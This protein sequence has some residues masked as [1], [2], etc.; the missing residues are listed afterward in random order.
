MI[1]RSL[2]AIFLFTMVAC[3]DTSASNETT[4]Q[5]ALQTPSTTAERSLS[6]EDVAL[7]QTRAANGSG[8]DAY[9]LSMY[10]MQKGDIS[11]FR[12]W[13]QI[14]AENGFP[15]GMHAFGLYLSINAFGDTPTHDSQIRAK[16]W[17]TRAKDAGYKSSSE[18]ISSN[19]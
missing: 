18:G 9:K 10:Y 7:L 4:E 1:Y 5:P 12:H 11:D 14:S 13:L 3:V 8:E 16:Y 6:N 19:Q 2:S 17:L 15:S